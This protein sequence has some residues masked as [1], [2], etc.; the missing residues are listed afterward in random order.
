MPPAIMFA[1]QGVLVF[2]VDARRRS[3]AKVVSRLDL[4]K[5][6]G[7]RTFLGPRPSGRP[8][9]PSRAFQR[10]GGEELRRCPGGAELVIAL[11]GQGYRLALVAEEPAPEAAAALRFLGL[12]DAFDLI[13]TADDVPEGRPSPVAHRAAARLLAHH[14]RACVAVENTPAGVAAAKAAGMR[15]V[16]VASTHGE[17]DLGQADMVVGDVSDLLPSSFVRLIGRA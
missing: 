9:T 10:L 4:L 8:E 1:L 12:D 7:R 16:A 2:H 11:C 5:E 6:G 13:L 17:A 15:C 14:P 3:L